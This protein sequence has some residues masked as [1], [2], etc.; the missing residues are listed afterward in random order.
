LNKELTDTP[1][2][3]PISTSTISVRSEVDEQGRSWAVIEGIDNWDQTQ[4]KEW[5][6]GIPD[7]WKRR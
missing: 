4:V 5:I 2:E 3:Q 6:G 1:S 7:T